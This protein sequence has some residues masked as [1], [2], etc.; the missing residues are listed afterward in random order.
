MEG[1]EEHIGYGIKKGDWGWVTGWCQVSRE[2]GEMKGRKILKVHS[3]QK[4]HDI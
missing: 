4:C 1:A 3:V 2:V